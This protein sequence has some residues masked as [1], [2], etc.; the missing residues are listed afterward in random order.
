V[1]TKLQEGTVYTFNVDKITNGALSLN[2]RFVLN[3][4]YQGGVRNESIPTGVSIFGD[5]GKIIL[6]SPEVITRIRVYDLTGR[7]I[8]DYRPASSGVI[9]L[10]ATSGQAF[11]VRATIS[12]RQLSAK[13]FVQ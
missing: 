1:E 12:G 6:Q 3:L 11:I 4:K 2:D 10:P 7:L 8:T 5:K 13:V 9:N